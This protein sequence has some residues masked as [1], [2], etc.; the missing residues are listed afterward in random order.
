MSF[1]FADYMLFIYR[2]MGGWGGEGKLSIVVLHRILVLHYGSVL[3]L[4]IRQQR[5]IIKYAGSMSEV[6]LTYNYFIN[7]LFIKHA[8]ILVE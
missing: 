8:C 7:Q 5:S 3:M 4:E 6:F 2:V 1:V